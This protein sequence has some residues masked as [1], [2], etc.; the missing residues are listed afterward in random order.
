MAYGTVAGSRLWAEDDTGLEREPLT[1]K[2]KVDKKPEFSKSAVIYRGGLFG[3]GVKSGIPD[4]FPA[5]EIAR[6]LTKSRNTPEKFNG[7]LQQRIIA[8][9]PNAEELLELMYWLGEGESEKACVRNFTEKYLPFSFL[10]KTKK[11]DQDEKLE[12]FKKHYGRDFFKGKGDLSKNVWV[13][14]I[15]KYYPEDKGESP[16]QWE[17]VVKMG[18]KLSRGRINLFTVKVYYEWEG[19][20]ATRYFCYPSPHCPP[21]ESSKIH[22]YSGCYVYSME[23]FKLK[24]VTFRKKVKLKADGPGKMPVFYSGDEFPAYLD[25]KTMSDRDPYPATDETPEFYYFSYNRDVKKLKRKNGV[26][27][28]NEF[29]SKD[30]DAVVTLSQMGIAEAGSREECAKRYISE[31]VKKR[32]YMVPRN[33][34]SPDVEK[35]SRNGKNRWQY[36]FVL[37]EHAKKYSGFVNLY[38]TEAEFK[39]GNAVFCS[40]ITICKKEPCDDAKELEIREI[41]NPYLEMPFGSDTSEFIRD[42]KFPVFVRT[43][44]KNDPRWNAIESYDQDMLKGKNVSGRKKIYAGNKPITMETNFAERTKFGYVEAE[45]ERS[46]VEKY[47]RQ[48]AK[49]NIIINSRK[50]PDIKILKLHNSRISREPYKWHFEFLSGKHSYMGFINMNIVDTVLADKPSMDNEQRK[51]I[52]LC[53]SVCMRPDREEKDMDGKD[54]ISNACYEHKL[55]GRAAVIHLDQSVMDKVFTLKPVK[56]FD[57]L[58]DYFF[59]NDLFGF[60]RDPE[61]RRI[62]NKKQAVDIIKTRGDKRR[63]RGSDTIEAMLLPGT[64]AYLTN[65]SEKINANPLK[66]FSDYGFSVALGDDPEKR[67]KDCAADFV[68]NFFYKYSNI[69]KEAIIDPGTLAETEKIWRKYD[70]TDIPEF[71]YSSYWKLDANL[72]NIEKSKNLFI[73]HRIRIRLDFQDRVIDAGGGNIKT[74]TFCTYSCYYEPVENYLD[75]GEF[76]KKTLMDMNATTHCLEVRRD[77]NLELANFGWGNESGGI[78]I[79][80]NPLFNGK[81]SEVFK[82]WFIPDEYVRGLKGAESES[83]FWRRAKK[84]DYDNLKDRVL[85]LDYIE[86]RK[87]VVNQ[88]GDNGATLLYEAVQFG[89]PELVRTLLKHGAEPD[90]ADV[91]GVTPFHIAAKKCDKKIAKMLYDKGADPWRFDK[92]DYTPFMYAAETGCYDIVDMILDREGPAILCSGIN[93]RQG[94]AVNV[95]VKEA[96]IALT[97]LDWNRQYIIDRKVKFATDM[98]NKAFAL[99]DNIH[100]IFKPDCINRIVDY[101]DSNGN[102]MLMMLAATG[103]TAMFNRVLQMTPKPTR[104]SRQGMDALMFAAI[105]G[106]ADIARTLISKG[107]DEVCYEYDEDELTF[108]EKFMVLTDPRKKLKKP[109]T[110]F[111]IA[112]KHGNPEVA[113]LLY[114]MMKYKGCDP[115]DA[116]SQLK[117]A[118]AN[119]KKKLRAIEKMKKKN[120]ERKDAEG[121]VPAYGKNPGKQAGSNSVA[122]KIAGERGKD[123]NDSLAYM[124][125]GVKLSDDLPEDNKIFSAIDKGDIAA[126]WSFIKQDPSIIC[127]RYI[128]NNR[129]YSLLT[130]AHDKMKDDIVDILIALMGP[131]YYKGINDPDKKGRTLLMKAAGFYVDAVKWLLV[132]GA[133]ATIT[134]KDKNTALNYATSIPAAKSIIRAYIDKNVKDKEFATYRDDCE[135]YTKDAVFRHDLE[136]AIDTAL[137]SDNTGLAAFLENFMIE[138]C[139]AIDDLE[140]TEVNY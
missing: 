23:D 5:G 106:N 112:V 65:D 38:F 104:K 54:K 46:C 79:I 35:I 7:Y 67:R 9:D 42:V 6:V 81:S 56:Y 95:A 129:E 97:N 17:Y 47:F 20:T 76:L 80:E 130:Y 36:D 49:E 123:G 59:N 26:Y 55:K 11:M 92:L 34:V 109:L 140:T 22:D 32:K 12:F 134:D 43:K 103:D 58:P 115:D 48:Y 83:S 101:K 68:K 70:K 78:L 118:G 60:N 138:G 13:L 8:A 61:R 21:R 121:T 102:T 41:K 28:S 126:L 99:Y 52:K 139:A 63:D 37:K 4:Y 69:K 114:D 40:G 110:A 82:D 1:V 29:Y 119:E 128:M 2:H 105:G 31:Y 116:A 62:R 15:K 88:R 3:A 72:R 18:Q 96:N 86:N 30:H 91:Q 87:E 77:K 107:L 98:L 93:H 45:D 85:A 19:G 84:D 16:Y 33:L 131:C 14:S 75:P 117:K 66:Y 44:S 71:L 73:N 133:D 39:N 125:G 27:R 124:R 111:N 127:D 50:D 51:R 25:W 136:S 132:I 64:V 10:L 113:K 122:V 108:M 137:K 135:F 90:I 74:A 120:K 100:N 89:E 57:S 24:T 94:T 53:Y